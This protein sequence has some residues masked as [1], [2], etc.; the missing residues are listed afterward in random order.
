M[1]TEE[2]RAL[3]RCGSFNRTLGELLHQ[4]HQSMSEATDEK[5]GIVTVCQQPETARHTANSD[6]PFATL[7]VVYSRPLSRWSLVM[8]S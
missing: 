3:D 5:G 8:S 2:D 6:S 1:R 7:R 4:V